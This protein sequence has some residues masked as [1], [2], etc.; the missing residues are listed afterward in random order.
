M[1]ATTSAPLAPSFSGN[2]SQMHLTNLPSMSSDSANTKQTGITVAS[3]L[4]VASVV[5][6]STSIQPLSAYRPPT[7]T[8]GA[9]RAYSIQFALYIIL[10]SVALAC[11]LY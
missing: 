6:H 4:S 5:A 9:H 3:D 7:A 8:S 10:L 2:A 1:L 11:V